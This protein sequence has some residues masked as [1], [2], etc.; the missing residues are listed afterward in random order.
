MKSFRLKIYQCSIHR[1][2][3]IFCRFVQKKR[4]M[5][6]FIFHKLIFKQKYN[7]HSALHSKRREQKLN[8][9]RCIIS[10]GYCAYYLLCHCCSDVITS[11]FPRS[12]FARTRT[13][14]VVR[15]CKNPYAQ[16]IISK[17]TVVLDA[18]PLLSERRNES[19][20]NQPTNKPVEFETGAQTYKRYAYVRWHVRM[21][22]IR[23]T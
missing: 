13:G 8:R 7:T 6:K 19:A 23:F 18:L 5:I 9:S 21:G 11:H 4:T 2:E 20:T 17:I 10:N 15:N 16:D 14:C 1:V 3:K 12:T 22:V